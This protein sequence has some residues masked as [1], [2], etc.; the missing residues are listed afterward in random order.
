MGEIGSRRLL[1]LQRCELEIQ[2]ALQHIMEQDAR[3]VLGFLDWKRERKIIMEEFVKD[4][5]RTE[6]SK[7][8]YAA[9]H[10]RL[11]DHQTMRLLHVAM[12]VASEAGEFVGIL[13]AHIFYGK[14]LD[15]FVKNKLI[16]ELGDQSWYQRI[17][18]DTLE[19]AF[20][21]MIERNVRELKTRYPEKFSEENAL[22]RDEGREMAAALHIPGSSC[23]E[24]DYDYSIYPAG[25]CRKCGAH[26]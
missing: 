13:K 26:D 3:W 19:V 7:E 24:H 10:A 23:T 4:A 18:C 9:A 6:P 11:A 16:S 21:A 14:P 15:E 17:G 8:K 22:V 1:E 20:A 2:E 25:K 5:L 12:G